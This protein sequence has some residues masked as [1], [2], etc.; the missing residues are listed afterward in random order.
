MTTT[1]ATAVMVW[2]IGLARSEDDLRDWW[3]AHQELL[4][5]LPPD[6]LAKVVEA[7]DQRKAALPQA[8]G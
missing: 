8:S 1:L 3:R 2:A 4:K 6:Q 5:A 7:K